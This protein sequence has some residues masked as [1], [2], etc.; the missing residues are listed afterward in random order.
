MVIRLAE[1]YLTYAEAAVETNTN[2]AAALDYIN[3]I[4]TRSGHIKA[5]TLTKALVRNERRVELAFEGLRYLD[6]MR[7]DLGPQ[8]L[9]GPL[10]GSRR[11]TMNFADGSIA[12]VGNGND[13]NDVN[14]IKLETRTFNPVRKYLFPIPQAEMDANKKMV[15]NPGY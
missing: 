7:W 12:W 4:R 2:T 3:A 6:V 10:Y 5:T 9:N 1:M 11:G 8:V 14:Y 13:V 15:Q